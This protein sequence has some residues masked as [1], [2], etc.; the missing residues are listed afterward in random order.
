MT[1]LPA[2]NNSPALTQTAPPY[3]L[4]IAG[5][6]DISVNETEVTFDDLEDMIAHIRDN[7]VPEDKYYRLVGLD[8]SWRNFSGMALDH[9]IFDNCD[10]SGADF[11]DALFEGGQV[12]SCSFSGADFSHARLYNIMLVENDFTDVSFRKAELKD[13]LDKQGSF[14]GAQF[15]GAEI[16]LGRFEGTDISESAFPGAQ[17][18][19][20]SFETVRARGADLTDLAAVSNIALKDTNLLGAKLSAQFRKAA[21][22]GTTFD[23]RVSAGQMDAL[24][25]SRKPRKPGGPR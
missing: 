17:I 14:V 16:V 6:G 8:L 12:K 9:C 20:V 10:L 25:R 5:A 18:K 21:Q 1:D 7:P 4:G 24:R 19:D 15:D 23:P 13:V 22:G 2:K 3:R 11:T